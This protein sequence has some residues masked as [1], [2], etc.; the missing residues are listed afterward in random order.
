LPLSVINID[1]IGIQ[2]VQCLF[3]L[4]KYKPLLWIMKSM[5]I[6]EHNVY[7]DLLVSLLFLLL[8]GDLTHWINNFLNLPNLYNIINHIL[9]C[10]CNYFHISSLLLPC[11]IMHC[12]FFLFVKDANMIIG[13]NLRL[14]PC[15]IVHYFWLPK[16]I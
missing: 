5:L 7:Y 8:L 16:N 1:M 6:C 11:I 3:F 10:L 9:F 15:Y 13:P 14:W 4:N 12:H 2:C